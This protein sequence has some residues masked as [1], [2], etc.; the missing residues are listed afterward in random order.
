MEAYAAGC[1]LAYFSTP[2]RQ[3]RHLNSRHIPE[4]WNLN[5][6]SHGNLKTPDDRSLSTDEPNELDARCA[7]INI[8]TVQTKLQLAYKELLLRGL[9]SPRRI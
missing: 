5:I 6:H 8:S 3:L 9:T 2:R 4:E 1:V 7:L